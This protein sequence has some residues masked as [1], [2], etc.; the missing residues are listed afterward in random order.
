MAGS[1]KWFRY[2]ADDGASYSINRDESTTELIN[3]NADLS[4]AP[5]KDVLPANVKPRTVRIKSPNGLAAREITILSLERY[6]VLS[7][8]TA[9]VMGA[10][11]VDTGLTFTVTSKR[12]ERTSRIPSAVDTGKL[13][14][15]QP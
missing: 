6:N 4:V 15:D 8:V 13:D 10:N 14:G 5:P 2:L 11:D 3:V 9:V 7:G 1:L 12:G